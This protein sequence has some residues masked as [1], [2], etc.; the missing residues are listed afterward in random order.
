MVSEQSTQTTP[1]PAESFLWIGSGMPRRLQGLTIAG[2]HPGSEPSKETAV[3][4]DWLANLPKQQQLDQAHMPLHPK[5]YGQGLLMTGKPGTGKTTLAAAVIAEVRRRGKSC[6]FTRWPEH[7]QAHRDLYRLLA[8]D[9]HSEE[10]TAGLT[11]AERVRTSFLVLLDD[12]GSERFTDTGFGTELLETTLR[13]RYDDGLPTI[14]TTNLTSAAW[15]ARY[16]PALRS[17]MAQA[18]RVVVF[19]GPDRRAAQ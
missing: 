16:S 7:V 13:Q 8:K 6:Y 18:C 10:V 2:L 4:L 12:V 19:N 1:R 9:S 3:A 17:F 15:N 11:A 5:I 14:V